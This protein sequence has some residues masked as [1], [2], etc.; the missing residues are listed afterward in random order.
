MGATPVTTQQVSHMP[1]CS[2]PPSP[3]RYR[4]ALVLGAY[5]LS[6]VKLPPLSGNTR[7]IKMSCAVRTHSSEIS[8]VRAGLE[9]MTGLLSAEMT[10]VAVSMRPGLDL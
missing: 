6:H 8:V 3:S 10:D 4:V 9:L 1:A 7:G 2:A 5:N